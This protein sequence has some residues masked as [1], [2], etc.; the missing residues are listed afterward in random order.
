MPL[1]S[2]QKE[3]LLNIA[4]LAVRKAVLKEKNELPGITDPVLIEKR[5]AFVTLTEHGELRGC[6]GYVLPIKPLYETVWDVAQEAAVGDP[7]FNPV[8]ASEIPFL[9]YEISALTPLIR[10]ADIQEITVGVHGLMIKRGYYSGLLLPQV[11]ISE[12]WSLE[13]FLSYTCRK[14]WMGPDCWKDAE[15]EIYKFEAEV[16]S[17]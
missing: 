5:G 6:I 4:K 8:S 9:K 3:I 17:D 7:R 11:A 14:A 13:E 10:V 12:H 15:T 1:S 16:F 2:K